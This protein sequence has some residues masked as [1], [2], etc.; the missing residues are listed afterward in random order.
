MMSS[1]VYCMYRLFLVACRLLWKLNY[2]RET[3]IDEQFHR[4]SASQHQFV[5]ENGK[6][7]RLARKDT[8]LL[9]KTVDYWIANNDQKS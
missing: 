5:W 1:I 4:S 6:L 7:A 3:L 8:N 2:L 9:Y